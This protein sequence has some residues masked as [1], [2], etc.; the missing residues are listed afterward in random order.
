MVA[1]TRGSGKTKMGK[2]ALVLP[3]RPM[4]KDSIA[5]Y[6]VLLNHGCVQ[7][8]VWAFFLVPPFFFIFY[9]GGTGGGYVIRVVGSPCPATAGKYLV[10]RCAGG[11]RA[12][13][14]AVR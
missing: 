13:V 10:V 14:F 7:R 12:F 8:R 4:L 2:V 6:R 3:T 9:L 1:I 11:C 5:H